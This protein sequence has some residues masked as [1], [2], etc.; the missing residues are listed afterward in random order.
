[1]SS[2]L[3]LV[4]QS[5]RSVAFENCKIQEFAIPTRLLNSV[6]E[7]QGEMWRYGNS[8]ILSFKQKGTYGKRE[9]ASN[10]APLSTQRPFRMTAKLSYSLGVQLIQRLIIVEIGQFTGRP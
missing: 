7:D 6:S 1:M 5:I 2:C 8:T 4:S 9:R 10:V 3:K